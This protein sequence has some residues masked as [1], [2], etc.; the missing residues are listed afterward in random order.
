MPP[1]KTRAQASASSQSQQTM[2]QLQPPRQTRAGRK[3]R[4]SDASE[5][6][7]DRPSSSQSMN[8]P[9]IASTPAKRRKRT[10]A[11]A[12]VEPEVIVE[13]EEEVE[14]TR[15]Q[16]VCDTDAVE[17]ADTAMEETITHQR[18]VKHVQ[19]PGG[20][21]S[22]TIALND[23]DE[24]DRTTATH[25]TPYPRRLSVKRRTTASP[26]VGADGQKRQKV[27]SSRHSL[28]P[29]LLKNGELYYTVDQHNMAPLSE[30][31]SERIKQRLEIH[32]RRTA[33]IKELEAQRPLLDGPELEEVEAQLTALREQRDHAFDAVT[34][35]TDEEG[36]DPEMLVLDS[37]Q[38]FAY[39][40][41][42]RESTSIELSQSKVRQSLSL[43]QSQRSK[44]SEWELEREQFRSAIV[45]LSNQA[46]DA[47]TKL[48]ILEIELSSLGMGE[49]DDWR[50][51]LSSIRE[52][53]YSVREQLESALPGSVPEDASN[54]DVIE[55]LLANVQEFAARLRT[56]DQEL[57]D[58]S[59]LAANLG[60]QVQ[61][62]L[63]HLAEAKIE[64]ERLV[65][66]HEEL[67]QQKA[68]DH[69][70]ALDLEAELNQVA[71]ERDLKEDELAVAQKS[72]K[73]YEITVTE[74]TS[75]IEK[76]TVSLK[77]YQSE[78]T[79]LT[80]LITR[81]EQE[82]AADIAHMN[83]EREETVRELEDRFDA[84]VVLREKAEALAEERHDTIAILEE[85]KAAAEQQRELLQVQLEEMTSQRDTEHE[86]RED[87]E[88][89]LRERTVEVENLEERVDRLE[90]E[91]ADLNT[92]ID[93][94]R[95]LN[96]T[97]RTQR[98]TAEAELDTAQGEIEELNTK[99]Q[100][101][102]AQ[103]NELR[104]KLWQVQQTNDQKVKELEQTA[105]ERDQQ[106]QLDIKE[107]VDRR[108]VVEAD[109]QDR[110]D[111]IEELK[112][113]LTELESKM[114]GALAERDGRLLILEQEL[115]DKSGEIEELSADLQN[116]QNLYET[117]VER[118]KEEREDL[119]RSIVVLQDTITGHETRIAT[120][121]QETVSESALHASEIEDR[122]ARIAQLNHEVAE[123]TEQVRELLVEKT[124]LEK[125]VEQEAE[126]M[127]QVQAEMG[128][129]IDTLKAVVADKQA[130]IAVVEQKAVEADDRWQDVLRAREEDIRMLQ[131][132]SVTTE[133]TVTTMNTQNEML[134]R[135]FAEYVRRTSAK[136]R[137]M[138]AEQARAHAAFDQSGQDIEKDGEAALLE[139]E[140]MDSV[141]SLVSVTTKKVVNGTRSEH[142][143]QSS[144]A[145]RSKKKRVMDSGIGIEEDESLLPA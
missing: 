40:D 136:I 122:N 3:R 92:Q 76:L 71:D 138:R 111:V 127:L 106:Y 78:E 101:A 59:N 19:F 13:E 87:A 112:A 73:D 75:S 88:M 17:G 21:Q 74:L 90:E 29:A 113:Q 102:G 110:E 81:M 84:Q 14:E 140:E 2:E 46:N 100:A 85:Q 104:Q 35:S 143:A 114:A 69:E 32:A 128:D 142:S 24:I 58:K 45:T 11:A 107:E 126:Q 51:V 25:I 8:A 37:Q 15:L 121:Q 137:A 1:K 119:E 20:R 16:P 39:P 99:L 27:T 135:K 52:S 64:N 141:S 47:R 62:L 96:E 115:A 60:A 43:S 91:L 57:Y 94:L 83:K 41:L 97:E 54:G 145:S 89:D 18:T 56:Q 82:H 9:S 139:L 38:E 53:F 98:E 30:V 77:K 103:A 134:R 12:S 65:S 10:R 130:K 7:S 118:N 109:L 80:T 129:E 86:A 72:I 63:D 144:R 120:L 4:A 5:P 36:P 67:Q 93:E 26:G 70:T 6:A 66:A 44:E 23:D 117:E 33:Q 34:L 28:P 95:Q 123:L 22:Q 68:Q 116:T 124:S 132:Q 61:G 108:E 55:I 31:L 50:A 79:R 125:R 105:S 42:P 131:E 48:Q 133:E 49:G